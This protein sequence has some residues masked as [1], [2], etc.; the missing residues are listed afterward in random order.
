MTSKLNNIFFRNNEINAISDL[1]KLN[2]YMLTKTFKEKV[3]NDNLFH[4]K[5]CG[6][7]PLLSENVIN[8]TDDLMNI[9]ND[10]IKPRQ[11]DT[12]FWC[13]YIIAHGYN[14]YVQIRRNY[15]IKE[16]EEKC[17]IFEFVKSCP[18]KIKNTNYKITNVATQT[19]ISELMS[20]Q[21]QTSMLVMISMIVY[22]NINI[23]IIDPS[24][25]CMLEF[26]CNKD[27]IPRMNEMST[28]EHAD[29]FVIY[30]NEYGKYNLQLENISVS[31][32][33]E[34]R[35]KMISLEHYE[36]LFKSVSNYK[37]EEL[38][39]FARKLELLDSNKKYKKNELYELIS[40][41]CIWK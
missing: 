1:S 33:Y 34:M 37:V 27:M 6:V 21:K 16:L 31:K 25:K 23:L 7:L 32:I 38:E 24:K 30:K 2:N 39:E 35:S 19:I 5:E 18:S 36:K 40:E 13:L 4:N 3:I 9:E 26:W 22:Y 29:T 15:G 8:D 17:K 28:K 20:V 11:G 14:D 12:L 41:K 10:L